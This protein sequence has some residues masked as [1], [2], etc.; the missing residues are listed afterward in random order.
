MPTFIF[1][2]LGFARKIFPDQML[3]LSFVDLVISSGMVVSVLTF[4]LVGNF[5]KD[6][7]IDYVDFEWCGRCK[8]AGV[9][10]RVT[11][12][13]RMLHQIGIS[14]ADAPTYVG[15]IHSAERSYY[16]MRNPFLLIRMSS[17]PIM[18]VI[19]EIVASLVKMFMQIIFL[20]NGSMYV[21]K[22][23]KGI[24]DGI[25]GRSGKLKSVEVSHET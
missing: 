9:P 21:P 4:D 19:T 23:V 10:I 5:N 20:P 13:A 2:R 18:Y 7:F 1:D 15:S 12:N 8:M 14:N 11:K 3:D 6:L 17:L 22:M 25:R 16:K 24:F